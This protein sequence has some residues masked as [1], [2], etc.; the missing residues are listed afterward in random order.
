[1]IE[2]G[3]PRTSFG[4]NSARAHQHHASRAVETPENGGRPELQALNLECKFFLARLGQGKPLF[5]LSQRKNG[6]IE[7][8]P[9]LHSC[10]LPSGRGGKR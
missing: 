1:M 5:R 3:S 9:I 7:C 10:L 4:L 2:V 8:L 6:A